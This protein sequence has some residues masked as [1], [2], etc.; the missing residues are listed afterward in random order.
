[1]RKFIY[2]LFLIGLLV[3]GYSCVDDFQDANPPRLLDSPAVTTVTSSDPEI[4]EGEST[5]ITATVVDAPAGV[6]SVAVTA[7]DE[8]ENSVGSYTV[9][10]PL[11]GQT[12]GDIEIT[13]TAPMRIMGPVSVAVTV[14]DKQFDDKGKVVRKN[15]V[16]KSTEILV[17]CPQPLSGNYTVTGQFLKDDFDS[18][19]VIMDQALINTDCV[20][21]YLVEDLSGGLYTNTYAEEYGTDPVEAEIDIDPDTNLVT[22]EGVSDQFGGDII[23]D[24]TQPDSFF[25]PDTNTI[26]IYWTATTYG[27]RGISTFVKK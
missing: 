1:M 5:T 16:P 10:T 22:W 21:K 26:T 11:T 6:D 24:D 17:I 9:D 4:L 19:D 18:P 7:T 27:E 23:Q 8:A 25:D 14:Y 20:S 13:Y 12:A 2:S 15:S 3:L